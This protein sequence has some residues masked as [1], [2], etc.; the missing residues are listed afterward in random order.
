MSALSA[1]FACRLASLKFV[2]RANVHCFS[3]RVANLLLPGRLRWDYGTRCPLS[4]GADRSGFISVQVM[5]PVDRA[6]Q[7]QLRRVSP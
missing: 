1:D 2:H 3:R 5:T 4:F 6:M 7:L